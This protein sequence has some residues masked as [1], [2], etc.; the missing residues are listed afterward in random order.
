M[1]ILIFVVVAVKLA[2]ANFFEATEALDDLE[3]GGVTDF[4]D[5]LN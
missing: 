4:S 3:F 5:R 1:I 2:R